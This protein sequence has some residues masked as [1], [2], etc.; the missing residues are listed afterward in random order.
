MREILNEYL[1][2][3]VDKKIIQESIEQNKPLIVTGVVQRAGVK[4]QNGRVYPRAVL[5]PEIK[6][7]I[8]NEIRE[9]RALGE[10]DHPDSQVVSL[11]NASHIVLELNWKGNDVIGKIKILDTPSGRIA[12][13]LFRE[14]VKIGISSRAMGSTKNIDESTVEV[15]NDLSIVSFDLVSSP[16]TQFAFLENLNESL[17]INNKLHKY[18]RLNKIITD[19]L[20]TRI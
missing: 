5:E 14:G 1:P 7:Y 10:L 8:D 13:E 20:T 17:N 4:N 18:Y 12:K 3:E 11:A 9:N 16:S 19:I 2:F 15:E 6:R